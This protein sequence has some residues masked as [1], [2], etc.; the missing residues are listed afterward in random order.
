MDRQLVLTSYVPSRKAGRILRTDF[1][2]KVIRE[3]LKSG[4]GLR[5]SIPRAARPSPCAPAS[6]DLTP[7]QAASIL[8]L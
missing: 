3:V 2:P 6:A 4:K 8:V 5:N 1:N 7:S